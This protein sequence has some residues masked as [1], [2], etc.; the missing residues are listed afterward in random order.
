MGSLR[1]LSKLICRVLV[2]VFLFAQLAISG[3]ACPGLG[4]TGIADMGQQAQQ[5]A[6]MPEGCDQLDQ[7]AP[8]LCAEHCKVGQQSSD[9]APVPVVIAP[10]LTLLYVL[11]DEVQAV[12][13]TGLSGTSS[14]PLIAASPPPHALLHCVL[15]I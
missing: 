2:G 14:D 7:K 8:N 1:T 6:P 4:Q 15:R 12:D 13:G 5:S 11:P 3:Y 9:T 10:A